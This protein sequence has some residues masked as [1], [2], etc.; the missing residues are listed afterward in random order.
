M[1]SKLVPGG[2]VRRSDDA[3]PPVVVRV[4]LRTKTKVGELH[5][6]GAL[7]HQHVVTL[8]VS[9]DDLLAVQVI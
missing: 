9:V 3:L 8:D 2:H 4:Q 6:A 7:V 1:P 5:L